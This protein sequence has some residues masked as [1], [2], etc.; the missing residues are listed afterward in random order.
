[1][2]A[3]CARISLLYHIM[4]HTVQA[5]SP[6]CHIAIVINRLKVH[7]QLQL[8]HTQDMFRRDEQGIAFRHCHYGE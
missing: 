6:I 5:Y 7:C 8:F 3:F 4:H 2:D 1:M